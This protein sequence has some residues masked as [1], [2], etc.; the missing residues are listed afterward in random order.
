MVDIS[1]DSVT[2][3][4]ETVERNSFFMC[5]LSI[6]YSVLVNMFAKLL[7]FFFKG[8]IIFLKEKLILLIQTY[9]RIDRSKIQIVKNHIG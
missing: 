1:P 5:F 6:A 3:V 4:D 2:S 9:N 8:K 7:L